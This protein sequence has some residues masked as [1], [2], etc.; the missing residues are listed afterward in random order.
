MVGYSKETASDVK[1][2]LQK[3][4]LAEKIDIVEQMPNNFARETQTV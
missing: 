4:K 3:M 1:S 2:I